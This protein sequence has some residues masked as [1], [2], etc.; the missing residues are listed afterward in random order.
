MKLTTKQKINRRWKL[1]RRAK[2]KAK[3]GL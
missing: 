3:R 1:K 2:R